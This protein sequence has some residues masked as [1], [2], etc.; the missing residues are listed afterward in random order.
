MFKRTIMIINTLFCYWEIKLWLN[1]T[2]KNKNKNIENNQA[3]KN[4]INLFNYLIFC[5]IKNSWIILEWHLSTPKSPV[6]KIL[7]K[8]LTRRNKDI[9]VFMCS[10]IFFIYSIN[11]IFL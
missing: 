6:Y 5:R 4:H 11:L 9:F 3:Y 2:L 1:L 10:L 8:I 7:C